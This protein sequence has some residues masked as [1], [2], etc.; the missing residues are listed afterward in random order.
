MECLK[1]D[2]MAESNRTQSDQTL[3]RFKLLHADIEGY[4]GC[5]IPGE[6]VIWNKPF[7]DLSL[8]IVLKES[9]GRL[10][11]IICKYDSH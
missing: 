5:E 2:F 1:R 9:I 11:D 4:V 8:G 10:E 3:E 7:S 6:L